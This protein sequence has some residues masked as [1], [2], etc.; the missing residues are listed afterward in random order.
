LLGG[1]D[2]EEDRHCESGHE[3]A[4]KGEELMRNL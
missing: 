1:A 2:L 3:D 4:D